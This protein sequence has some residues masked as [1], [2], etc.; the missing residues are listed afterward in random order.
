MEKSAWRPPPLRL[1]ET[2]FDFSRAYI[3]GILN[4]TPDSFSDGGQLASVA[5]AARRGTE[6]VEAGADILDIGGESTRPGAAQVTTTEEIDRVLPVIEGL[7][8]IGVPLSVD[9]TKA[10]VAAASLEAGAAIVND[11]SGGLFDAAMIDTVAA[12]K[13]CYVL[14]HVRGGTIAE[15]HGSEKASI[16]TLDVQND[17]AERLSRLPLQ[18]RERTVLDPGLGFGKGRDLNL[19]LTRNSSE[20]AAALQCPVMI[21]P[22]R[23]RYLGELCGGGARERD[24]ATIGASLAAVAMGAH[25]IRVHAVARMRAALTAFEASTGRVATG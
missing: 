25:F 6:L 17:L 3:V 13:A 2:L 7:R 11:I 4:V 22:S 5:E 14:G 12:S 20:L 16:S 21:G 15:V 1:G 8:G 10:S 9:T 24:D 19:A 18:L 23:K